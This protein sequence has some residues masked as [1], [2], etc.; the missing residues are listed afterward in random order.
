MSVSL[1]GK[2][3][4]VT[5]AGRG[6]GRAIAEGLAGAGASVVCT[7]RSLEEIAETAAHIE[8]AGG[9]AAAVRADVT[10]AASLEAAFAQAAQRFGGVDIVFANAGMSP[11]GTVAEGDPAAWRQTIETNVIGVFQ[12][13]RAAVP[14]LRQRGGGK[15]IVIGSGAKLT[16]GI[17]RSAYGA[18]QAAAWMLVQTLGLELRD[19]GI[20]VNELVPGPVSTGMTNFGTREM[21]AG[22]WVKQPRD[23]VP[24][25]L[26]LASHPEP[27]PTSQS[28]SLMRRA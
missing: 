5:G 4:L 17:G 27:G 12:T 8:G 3:A 9:R 10:D 21:P 11:R 19:E 23:V 15:I 6:I 22:E 13:A 7:A 2:V 1:A 20:S 25:A 28:F 14:W 16:A 26:F 24:L 18:S